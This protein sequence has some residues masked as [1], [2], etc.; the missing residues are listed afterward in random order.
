MVRRRRVSRTRV[1]KMSSLL[2][3]LSSVA[4]NFYSSS[5]SE[6]EDE[7]ERKIHVEI[8]PLNNGTA[9]ISASVDELRATV[10]NLSLSPIGALS[11]KKRFHVS[12]HSFSLFFFIGKAFSR[13]IL[14]SCFAS[15]FP[16][17][18]HR[19]NRLDSAV[20]ASQNEHSRPISLRTADISFSNLFAY[21]CHVFFFF[22]SF[23]VFS[24]SF[25]NPKQKKITENHF[26]KHLRQ[27]LCFVTNSTTPG[28]WPFVCVCIFVG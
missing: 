28:A 17:A 27:I 1:S 23:H 6:S 13:G 18:M 8:K 22:I 3:F 14:L 26:A 20:V 21:P 7:I 5:D 4:G 11:V 19:S 15:G 16:G 2:T 12:L 24:S 9:P 10:E 25:G